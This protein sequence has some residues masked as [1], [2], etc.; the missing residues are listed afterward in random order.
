M[1]KAINYLAGYKWVFVFALAVA[2]AAGVFAWWSASANSASL[3]LNISRLGTQNSTDYKYDNYYALRASDEFGSVVEG[4]FKTPE[5]T[6]AVYKEAGLDLNLHSLG[7][8]SRFFKAGKISPAAV[9]VRFSVQSASE[10]KAISQAIIKISAQR[11]LAIGAASNQ[12]ISFMI[13]G[14]EPVVVD[15][16]SNL[17]RNLLAGFIMGLIIGF[18]VKAAREY[19]RD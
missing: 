3:V 7:S 15:N 10:A 14:S 9:E 18:F 13:G 19:F 17:W 8:L 1:K 6:Q 5:M 2:V 12:G 11:A 4:W 16:S